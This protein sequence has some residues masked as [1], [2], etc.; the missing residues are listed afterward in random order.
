MSKRGDYLSFVLIMII[1]TL[2]MFGFGLAVSG[3]AKNENQAAPLANLVAF[4]MM[5]LS[6]V[7]FP[8]FVMPE[9]LQGI[10]TYVPLTPVI[11]G[12]RQIITE[13]RTILEIGP[14]LAI[15][16]AWTVIVYTIAAKTFRWE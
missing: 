10:T 12:T 11:D 7:F 8:R 15:I 4:P 13:G 1:G 16:G 2:S 5:F 3:W 14:E 9:W 6:G